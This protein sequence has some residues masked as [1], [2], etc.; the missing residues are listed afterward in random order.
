MTAPH[1]APD[2]ASSHDDYARRF[3][4][5]VGRWFLERQKNIVLELLAPLGVETILEVGGGHAQLTQSLV[6][7]GYKVSV[8]GSD[9][10]CSVRLR[11]IYS[12]R[13]VPFLLGALEHLPAGDGTFDA[14]V[15]VRTMAHVDDPPVFLAECA[16]VARRAI[17]LDYPSQRSVNRFADIFFAAKQSIEHD[18]RRYRSFADADVERWMA[19]AGFHRKRNVRQFFWPMAIHRLH[20]NSS[21]AAALEKVPQLVGLTTALGSPVLALY[22][23]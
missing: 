4:G 13:D 8:Q 7:A 21:A 6:E 3:S 12:D 2:I 16:R 10:S 1:P 17:V 5:E 22:V 23:R 19:Q 9:V 14:V 11:R 15:T 18:T 20:K